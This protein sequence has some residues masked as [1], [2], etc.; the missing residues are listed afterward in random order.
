ML[1]AATDVLTWKI[2]RREQGLS[3]DDAEAAMRES[4]LALTGRFD[5][6]AGSPARE[7]SGA[8][9]G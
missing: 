6:G 3:R 7:A 8:V 5:A 4:V 9:G 2:L 1:I